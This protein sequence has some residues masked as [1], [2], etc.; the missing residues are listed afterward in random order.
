MSQRFNPKIRSVSYD[1]WTRIVSI[2]A[3]R[4]FYLF[5]TRVYCVINVIVQHNRILVPWIPVMLYMIFNKPARHV[6][7]MYLP[8]LTD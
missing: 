5:R 3:P 6:Q 1:I 2:F 4:T 8:Q 7:M